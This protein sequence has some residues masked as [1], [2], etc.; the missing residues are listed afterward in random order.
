MQEPQTNKNPFCF[1]QFK[2][3]TLMDDKN[4]PLMA[5]EKENDKK[6]STKE[7]NEWA[8]REIGVLWKHSNAKQSFY[9]GKVQFNDQELNIVCFSNKNKQKDSHPDIR[10]YLSD[11][12][13]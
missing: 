12:P 6:T 8:K 10:I 9:S 5:D 2:Q 3:N 1:K 11:A 4:N 7:E 13:K